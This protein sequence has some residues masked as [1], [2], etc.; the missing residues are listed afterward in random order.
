[1]KVYEI[2]K[3]EIIE[4]SS[5]PDIMSFWHGGD[6]TDT[7]MRPQKQGRFEYGAGLYLITRYDTAAKY[8]KGSRK[9]YMV[10]VRKGNE[11]SKVTLDTESSKNFVNTYVKHAKRKEV[12]DH[13][14]R[15]IE[16][17]GLLISINI[18]VFNTL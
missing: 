18:V 6:L 15:N 5:D 13:I 10:N 12:L 9:L 16:R 17:M 1:M 11:S 14:D 7:S 4:P 2:L 3:E 8:A